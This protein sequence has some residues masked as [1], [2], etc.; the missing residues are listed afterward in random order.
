MNKVPYN[1]RVIGKVYLMFHIRNCCTDSVETSGEFDL[2]RML[3]Q[4]TPYHSVQEYRSVV[5]RTEN[6]LCK[7]RKMHKM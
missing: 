7:L 2:V 6:G 5:Y 1:E 4:Y 3:V